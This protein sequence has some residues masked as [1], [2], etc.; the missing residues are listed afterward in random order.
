M[1][2]DEKARIRQ[3]RFEGMSYAQISSNLNISENTIKS[4]CRRNNLPVGGIILSPDATPESKDNTVCRH[5][6]KQLRQNPKHKP[7]KFCS[8]ACRR[9]WWKAHKENLDRKAIYHFTC[10]CCGKVFESYGNNRRKYCGHACYIKD[11]FGEPQK[12]KAR[13]DRD[14]GAV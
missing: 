1:T 14:I 5:C 6:G 4:F 7:K 12:T 9:A 13:N 8:D 10:A 2:T 11:R 3:M